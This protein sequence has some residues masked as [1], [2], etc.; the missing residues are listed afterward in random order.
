M[1]AWTTRP[2]D[3]TAADVAAAVVAVQRASYRVEADLI[4]YDRIPPLLDTA[5]DVAAL[6]LAVLGVH[7]DAGRLAG[8]VGY[9]VEVGPGGP[10]A[11]IER[12]A[13]DPRWFR[14][15]IGRAL[16]TAVHERE[17][18]AV[19]FTVSTGAANAPAV[20]LYRSLGYRPVGERTVEGCRIAAFERRSARPAHPPEEPTS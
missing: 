20:A 13:V 9:L 14:R 15:G 8:L 11:D 10:V 16:V 4:G 6:D 18:A 12:L 17:R 7:D 2:I 1:E 19:A 3:H 5:A